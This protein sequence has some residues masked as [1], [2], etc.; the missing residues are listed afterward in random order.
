MANVLIADLETDGFLDVVT[1][2]HCMTIID[3][4]TG[5]EFLYS[6]YTELHEKDW[7]SLEEGTHNPVTPLVKSGTLED[8]KAHLERADLV[9]G[10]N[11]QEFDAQVIRKIMGSFNPKM[12]RD[13]QILANM[14]FGA[15]KKDDIIYNAGFKKRGLKPPIPAKLVGK[16]KLQAWGIRLGVHKTDF[17]PSDWAFP[18]H[19]MFDYGMQDSRVDRSLWRLLR[20]RYPPAEAVDLNHRFAAIMAL[21]QKHGFPFDNEKADELFEIFDSRKNELTEQ[22]SLTIP[23]KTVVTF[24]KVKRIRKVRVV[25]FNPGSRTQVAAWLQSQ[26]WVH[27]KEEITDGGSP[28]INDGVLLKL[29]DKWPECSL[30]AEYY[31]IN[32]LRSYLKD[33]KERAEKDGRIHGGVNTSAASTDRNTHMSPN[34]T[35][36]PAE[37]SLYGKECRGLFYC[38]PVDDG[39]S[40]VGS[41]GAS[42]QLRLLGH[43]MAEWDGG[44]YGRVCE[45]SD[46]HAHTQ[47]IIEAPPGKEGRDEA[48]TTMYTVLFGGGAELVGSRCGHDKAWGEKTIKLLKKGL[49]GFKEFVA[50]LKDDF[51]TK[52]YFVALDGRKIPIGSAHVGLACALQSAEAIVMKRATV[53]VHDKLAELGWVFGVDYWNAAHIHDEYQFVVK[54]E[55]VEKMMEVAAW[56]IKAAGEFYNLKVAM[57][58]DS[59]SGRN[60]SETH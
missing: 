49:I 43:Y 25:P 42:I 50:K 22:L 5:E 31:K 57:K 30:L 16:H 48:K 2:I 17:V 21:Q 11:F 12:I 3:D 37:G 53:L 44:K 26:G 33:W 59:V 35:Q 20:K 28:Q 45:E 32:K 27:N 46:P 7:G 51:K 9:V 54:N 38:G 36:V 8:G 58:G 40:L 39:N 52:G 14:C 60:W 47:V 18:S 24:S 19:E 4:A 41:D 55:K 29:V 56:G 13:T 23:A 15:Q 10:H 34:V 1:K 6:D